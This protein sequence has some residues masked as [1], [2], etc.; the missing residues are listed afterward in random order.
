MEAE[1]AAKD[2]EQAK[3]VCVENSNV[4]LKAAWCSEDDQIP[5]DCGSVGF[6]TPITFHAL[7]NAYQTPWCSIPCT[8]NHG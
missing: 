8:Y 4:V 2:A 5:L 6:T 1:F 7:Y 3:N